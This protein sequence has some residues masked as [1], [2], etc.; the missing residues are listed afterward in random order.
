MSRWKLR[1]Y[2]L[3]KTSLNSLKEK[4]KIIYSQWFVS[5]IIII[6]EEKAKAG[7]WKTNSN[8]VIKARKTVMSVLHRSIDFQTQHWLNKVPT[9]LRLNGGENKFHIN[10]IKMFS[11]SFESTISLP[12]SLQDFRVIQIINWNEKRADTIARAKKREKNKLRNKM[13]MVSMGEMN[14]WDYKADPTMN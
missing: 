3:T 8:H 14:H 13:M 5:S 10:V 12:A 6:N 1:L 2:Q 4:W 9:Q 7:K 11:R